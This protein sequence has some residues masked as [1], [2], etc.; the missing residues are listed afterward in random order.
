MQVRLDLALFY[1]IWPVFLSQF[2]F[3]FSLDTHDAVAKVGFL[4]VVI[5]YFEPDLRLFE[6]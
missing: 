3:A 4:I 6:I 5:D 2:R 1:H